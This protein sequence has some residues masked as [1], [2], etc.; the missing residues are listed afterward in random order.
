VNEKDLAKK[1]IRWILCI[2]ALVIIAVAGA[3][4]VHFFMMDL[5][6]LWIKVAR[7]FGM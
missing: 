5:D 1:K 4:A 2:M 6:V 7:R 3:A